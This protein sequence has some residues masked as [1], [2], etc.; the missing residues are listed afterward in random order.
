MSLSTEELLETLRCPACL[1]RLRQKDEQAQDNG[2]ICLECSTCKEQF[3]IVRGVPRLL[4]SPLREALLGQQPIASD[5]EPQVKTALSFGFEWSRFPEMYK[6]WNQSF[7][8]YM[9]PHGPD[10]FRG[11]KVLDA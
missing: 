10:F 9:Q 3:P 2:D 11:K 8:D 4:L 7:L 6:E 1:S 5:E